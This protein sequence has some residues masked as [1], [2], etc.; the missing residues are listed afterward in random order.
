MLHSGGSIRVQYPVFRMRP[1]VALLAVAVLSALA[2]AALR[3]QDPLRRGFREGFATR[4]ELESLAT[5]AER[6]SAGKAFV[7]RQ[8]LREG[9]FQPGD[10]I[11]V[12]L[13]GAVKVNDTLVVRGTRTI[14][15]PD[16][17]EI[18]LAGVLRSEL[19]NYLSTQLGRYIRDP[20]VQTRPLLR[21]G[22]SGAVTRPGFYSVPADALLSDLVMAAGGPTAVVS[23]KH[24]AIRRG[25]EQLWDG[26]SV[27]VA[28]SDGLTADGLL[29]RSGDELVVGEKKQRN[30]QGAVQTMAA[31]MGVISIAVALRR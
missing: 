31:V 11:A 4:A 25:G 12:V 29:L 15:I 17:P 5:E 23:Y 24:S 7:L 16:I 13:D 22:I 9:D 27:E 18:S 26:K 20:Q 21:L 19:Q 10:R 8:R 3:G 6:E 28:L 1:A 30:W 14:S 2:P